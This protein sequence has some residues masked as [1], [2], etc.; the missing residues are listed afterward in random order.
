MP[1]GEAAIESGSTK[2]RFTANS[3]LQYSCSA[4][5]VKILESEYSWEW[6]FSKVVGI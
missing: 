5:V 4:T 2:N 6:L 3:V 1:P